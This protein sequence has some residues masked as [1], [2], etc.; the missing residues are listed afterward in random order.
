[1][2]LIRRSSGDLADTACA[3]QGRPVLSSQ[4]SQREIRPWNSCSVSPR[5]ESSSWSLHPDWKKRQ[6][7]LREPK[8]IDIQLRKVH[9]EM[10]RFKNKS[11]CQTGSLCDLGMGDYLRPLYVR[12]FLYP[13]PLSQRMTILAVTSCVWKGGWKEWGIT[14]RLIPFPSVSMS[15][16]DCDHGFQDLRYFW[17]CLRHGTMGRLEFKQ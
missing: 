16:S 8:G 14:G 4:R 17:W 10:L 6:C 12:F 3:K 13:H 9:N 11:K 5:A 1:M 2:V 15:Y 7:L